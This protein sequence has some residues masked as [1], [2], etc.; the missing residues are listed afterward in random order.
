MS[1]NTNRREDMIDLNPKMANQIDK[2][3]LEMQ[4]R[5]KKRMEQLNKGRANRAGATSSANANS[6]ISSS[7]FNPSVRGTVTRNLGF[8]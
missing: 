6:A 4:E 2:D 7:S 8:K 1:Q 5:R 3:Y